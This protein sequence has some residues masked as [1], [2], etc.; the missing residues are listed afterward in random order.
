VKIDLAGDDMGEI[1]ERLAEFTTKTQ[2][3]DLPTDIVHETKRLLL[4][5]VGI[6]LSGHLQDKGRIAGELAKRLGGPPEATV[7]GTNQRVS[8]ANAAFA[9]GES[10]NALDCDAFCSSH[11][12][13]A[14]IAASLALAESTQ[15]SGKDLILAVALGSEIAERVMSALRGG[16]SIIESGPKKGTI[17]WGDIWPGQAN[18]ALGAA[19]GA[20]KIIN[21]NQE[22]MAN[23]IGLAGYLCPPNTARKFFDTVGAKM[24]KYG[25]SGWQAQS[26]VTAALLAQIGFTGDTDIFEGEYGF[27]KYTGANEWRAERVVEDIGGEWKWKQHLNYKQY[28]CGG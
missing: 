2:F 3:D 8:C 20:C 1:T 13:P 6:A 27:W 25:I 19:A 5:T 15:A 10:A 26:G 23:A 17:Q 12:P 16:W 28:P 9:N 11:A 14:V 4:D 22:I 24:C 7:I 18:I 21:V